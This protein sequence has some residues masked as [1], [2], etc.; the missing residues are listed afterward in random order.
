LKLITT[1]DDGVYVIVAW[2]SDYLGICV[3]D[4]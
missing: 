3:S 2:I 4:M 1:D